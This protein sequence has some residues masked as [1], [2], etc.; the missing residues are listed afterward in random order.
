M[1][2]G[3]SRFG[4]GIVGLYACT[5]QRDTPEGECQMDKPVFVKISEGYINLALVERVV[6]K[7]NTFIVHFGDTGGVYP[8]QVELSKVDGEHIVDIIKNH[9]SIG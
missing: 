9:L 2:H 7:E 3:K 4:A 5:R 8:N 1:V 6:R